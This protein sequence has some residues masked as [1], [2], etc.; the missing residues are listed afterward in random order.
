MKVDPENLDWAKGEGLIPTIV[1][2]G[3]TG[4]VLMLAYMNQEA[5]EL[6]ISSGKVTFWSR[7]RQQLWTK[8]ETSGNHLIFEDIR[9]DCDSDTI[10]V[11][12][13]PLGPVCHR[14]TITCFEDEVSFRG[15]AFLNSLEDLIGQRKKDLPDGS[16]TAS[17][18]QK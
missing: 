16:Y 11:T 8:G 15:L 1:Q 10:L 12:A 14:G 2:D 5:F 7:S 13:R 9:V 4:Q 18:F 17:L 3:T 6:T